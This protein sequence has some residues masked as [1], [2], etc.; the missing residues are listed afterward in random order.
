MSIDV[1]KEAQDAGFV[2]PVA[3]TSTV[4]SAIEPDEAA[5]ASGETK[6]RAVR[7]LLDLSALALTIPPLRGQDRVCLGIT[8]FRDDKPRRLPLVLERGAGGGVLIMH[9]VELN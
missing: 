4:L 6:E 9:P 8:V 1:T 3:I 5:R 2:V 7:R